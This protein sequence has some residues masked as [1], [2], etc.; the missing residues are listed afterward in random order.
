MRAQLT[1]GLIGLL[2]AGLFTA[3]STAA[4]PEDTG[5]KAAGRYTLHTVR[6]DRQQYRLFM[7]D[8]ATGDIWTR[9]GPMSDQWQHRGKPWENRAA[10]KA[11]HEDNAHVDA[12]KHEAP[13]MLVY[14]RRS[15]TIPDTNG[16]LRLHIGDITG[17]QAVLHVTRRK[18]DEDDRSEMVVAPH[19]VR[20][21]ETVRVTGDDEVLTIKVRALN[22]FL[23]GED[24]AEFD[25]RWAPREGADEEER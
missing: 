17:G 7:V 25:V 16:R 21:G 6:I 2:I 15:K 9:T 4:P 18:S 20:E 1:I 11:Q 19:S 22:N 24:F 13:D 10:D 5:D 8:T 3:G 23:T 12:H 14:Q